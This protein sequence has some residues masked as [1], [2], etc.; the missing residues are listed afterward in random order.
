MTPSN[1]RTFLS[2]VGRGML[3]VGLGASLANDLGFSTTFAEQGEDGVPLG[4]YAGLV[5]VIAPMATI[6]TT[7]MASGLLVTMPRVNSWGSR[8]DCLSRNGKQTKSFPVVARRGFNP[9]DDPE[10]EMAILESNGFRFR[11]RKGRT[12]AVP[13]KTISKLAAAADVAIW[14]L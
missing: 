7:N 10:I 9:Q 12:F 14:T 6:A 5:E 11:A 2:D 1:R 8:C 13:I 4:E 3:A